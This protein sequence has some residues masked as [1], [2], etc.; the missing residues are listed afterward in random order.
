MSNEISLEVKSNAELQEKIIMLQNENF[1]LKVLILVLNLVFLSSVLCVPRIEL[2]FW[3]SAL[4]HLKKKT[5][6]CCLV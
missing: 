2:H 5:K 6:L 3:S 4:L 1:D